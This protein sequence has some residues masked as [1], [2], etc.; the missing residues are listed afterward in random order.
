MRDD[1]DVYGA[2]SRGAAPLAE[3]GGEG[4]GLYSEKEGRKEVPSIL[5]S[6]TETEPTVADVLLAGGVYTMA[7]ARRLELAGRIEAA[8]IT[9]AELQGLWD[10]LAVVIED[11]PKCQRMFAAKCIE[12]AGLREALDDLQ[13]HRQL[14]A[15]RAA[16][17][18]SSEHYWGFP[19]PHPGCG[20]QGCSDRRRAGHPEV[21]S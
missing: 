15:S 21:R 19:S 18:R 2:S 20:C 1:L 4:G 8:G 13:Q 6:R 11:G 16:P 10:Y 12:T 7:R 5:P 14:S 9:A 3:R 17:T